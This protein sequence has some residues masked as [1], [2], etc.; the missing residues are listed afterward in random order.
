VLL[1]ALLA[2]SSFLM[3]PFKQLLLELEEL[4]IL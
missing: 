3:Q 4:T 1:K 2:A